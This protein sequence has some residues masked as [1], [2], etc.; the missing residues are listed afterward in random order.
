MESE[1]YNLTLRNPSVLE[2]REKTSCQNSSEALEV[3]YFVLAIAM[4]FNCFDLPWFVHVLI[5]RCA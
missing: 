3:C 1:N 2:D 5:V 4:R